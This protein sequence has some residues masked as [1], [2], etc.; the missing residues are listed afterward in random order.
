MTDWR[1]GAILKEPLA[2]TLRF[3]AWYLEVGADG[4]TLFFDDPED[5]AIDVLRD[6]PKVTCVPC[7]PEFWRNIGVEPD[8]RFTRRQNLAVT[9]A[10]VQQKDGWFLNVDSD[11]FLYLQSGTIRDL[12][13]SQPDDVQAIRF[14][15]AEF[16]ELVE[17]QSKLTFRLPIEQRFKRRYI[18]GENAGLF[19]PRR[20][21]MVGHADGKSATRAGIDGVFLRQHWPDLHG[22]HLPNKLLGAESGAYLLHFVARD[23]DTWKR[24]VEW[25]TGSRGFARPL[26]E[27][28]KELRDDPYRD[29]QLQDLY[30]ALHKMDP[31]MLERLEAIGCR[32]DLDVDLDVIAEAHFGDAYSGAL[33]A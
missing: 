27:R 14:K 10:Y 12:L 13:A 2:D 3:V 22:K 18:Y 31:E 24:K 30:D 16:V 23:F 9:S 20:Q 28:L 19:G 7:T 32:L 15:V 11:E 29:V 1:V 5:P 21:G 6:H 26:A 33:P 8:V 4:L 17:P 25:R